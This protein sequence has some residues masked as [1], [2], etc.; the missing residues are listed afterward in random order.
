[1][2]PERGQ[3]ALDFPFP[4]HLPQ[5]VGTGELRCHQ[6]GRPHLE[7]GVGVRSHRAGQVVLTGKLSRPAVL[8]QS[9]AT[10]IEDFDGIHEGSNFEQIVP[11]PGSVA[12]AVEGMGDADKRSLLAQAT[13]GLVGREAGGDFFG[14][15]GSQDFAAG[16]HN[17]FANDDQFRVESVSGEGT[18]DGVV[19]GDNDPVQAAAAGG[20]NQGFGRSQRV[21]RGRCVGMK[22]YANHVFLLDKVNSNSIYCILHALR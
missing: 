7:R 17:L 15:E 3:P 22:V 6:T 20:A 9:Q 1:M 16:G 19:V 8:C 21:F 18:G 12:P 13:D 4:D 11:F 5:P 14:H 2:D 10:G